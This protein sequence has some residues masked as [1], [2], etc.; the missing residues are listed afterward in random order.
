MSTT[1]APGVGPTIAA[2]LSG[3]ELASELSGSA[4]LPAH[5]CGVY[6]LRPTHGLI[7]TVGNR[8]SRHECG[9]V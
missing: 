6:A 7:P 3:L 5:Y 2:G 4:R 8:A 1:Q 9:S